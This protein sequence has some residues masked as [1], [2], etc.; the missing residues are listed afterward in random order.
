MR[1]GY[2]S[3]DQGSADCPSEDRAVPRLIYLH[4]FASG[5]RSTKTAL[6]DAACRR[7]GLALA[8]PDLN[9]PSFGRLSLDAMTET[10][11]DVIGRSAARTF[12]IGSSLGAMVL[13]RALARSSAPRVDRV[14]LLAP[15][16]DH[17]LALLRVAGEANDEVWHTR[18]ELEFEHFA[19]G[20]RLALW[21]DFLARG[22]PL[23]DEELTRI[24]MPVLLL[25]ATGDGIAPP[26]EVSRLAHLLPNARLAEVGGGHQLVAGFD[27]T[28]SIIEEFLGLTEYQAGEWDSGLAGVDEIRADP[29]LV[30]EAI[31]TIT[32]A[33][34][35][36]SFAAEVHHKRLVD[37]GA[38]LTW[39]RHQARTDAPMVGA[40]YMGSDGKIG[41]IAVDPRYRRRGLSLLMTRTLQA[42]VYPQFVEVE[43]G[44]ERARRMVLAAGFRPVY[45]ERMAAALLQRSGHHIVSAGADRHGVRYRRLRLA[46]GHWD[47]M[48]V[49]T[50]G[51]YSSD[52]TRVAGQSEED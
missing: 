39:I 3:N 50:H 32:N 28:W 37:D 13:L 11:C 36:R 7:R 25:S 29:A 20:E 15:V 6:L 49:F 40:S 35:E 8:A 22:E 19:A 12:A 4:G 16:V 38:T 44:N 9:V 52:R 21:H 51:Y 42:A 31:A 27:A 33:Y 14:V 24:T 45:D 18:G 34:G 10:A 30:A 2:G 48:Q 43:C 5:P 1:A 26:D 47:D 17:R 23:G 41:A 46:A